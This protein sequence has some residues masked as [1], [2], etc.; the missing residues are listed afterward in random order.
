MITI[1][2]RKDSGILWLDTFQMTTM[3]KVASFQEQ[4]N[5]IVLLVRNGKYTQLFSPAKEWAKDPILSSFSE[6]VV[7]ESGFITVRLNKKENGNAY[8]VEEY[9][10]LVTTRNRENLTNS[11]S[12]DEAIACGSIMSVFDC[13][14]FLD[15]RKQYEEWSKQKLIALNA[16]W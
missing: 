10:I 1:G 6:L 8:S 14:Q 11:A 3:V 12:L 15:A 13:N 9:Q 4:A 7:D 5:I 2:R 16:Y